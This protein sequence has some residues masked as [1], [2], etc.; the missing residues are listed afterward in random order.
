MSISSMLEIGEKFLSTYVYAS[1]V[2]LSVGPPHHP[3]E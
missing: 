1:V 3:S 2:T